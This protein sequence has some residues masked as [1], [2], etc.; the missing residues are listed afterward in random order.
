M[1]P[2][3]KGKYYPTSRATHFVSREKGSIGYG[4]AVARISSRDRKIDLT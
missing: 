1:I 2:L 4:I 3:S